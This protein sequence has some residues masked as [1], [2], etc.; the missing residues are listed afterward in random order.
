MLRKNERIISEEQKIVR[1]E[2]RQYLAPDREDIGQ[3]KERVSG[4]TQI[5]GEKQTR[6]SKRVMESQET[7]GTVP[8]T[9]DNRDE[10]RGSKRR[11]WRTDT[12]RE[13]GLHGRSGLEGFRRQHR[14][15]AG[16][17]GGDGAEEVRGSQCRRLECTSGVG[18]ESAWAG[19]ERA[20]D[21]EPVFDSTSSTGEKGISPWTADEGRGCEALGESSGQNRESCRE[22]RNTLSLV[23]DPWVPKRIGSNMFEPF[24][25]RPNPEPDIGFGSGS[26]QVRNRFRTEQREHYV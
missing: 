7:T 6:A 21:R 22:S 25:D 10:P 8:R 14:F 5:T 15:E 26:V 17:D 3:E 23:Q 13:L 4:R 2:A 20:L 11:M 24:T 9:R 19:K 18:S 1:K 16:R 12:S